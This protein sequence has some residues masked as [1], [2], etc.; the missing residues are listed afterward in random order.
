SRDEVR[1][2]EMVVAAARPVGLP[3]FRWTATEGLTRQDVDSGPPQ[4]F[5]AEA[6]EVLRTIRQ[7]DLAG[8]Y[9][10]VD[11][12]P[13]L[14]DP[15]HVRLL[16]DIAQGYPVVARTVVL[17][18]YALD[19]PP[20]LEHLAARLQVALPGGPERLAI[21]ETAVREWS[22]EHGQ[23]VPV[24]PRARD[25]LVE[26]LRGL[27]AV[28]AERLARGAVADGA[29]RPS[30]LP[31]VMQ[32]KYALL[33]RD[34]VLGYEHDVPSV[35]D[36]GGMGRLVRWLE[37]RRAAFD[38]S[39]PD[40]DTPRGVLLVGVQGCGKS[41][42]AKA[43][44][45]VLGVPLLH[46]DLAAVHNKYV[47]E[48]ERILRETL[49]T[50][51]VLAPCVLWIDEIE[52]ALAVDEAGATRRV[53]GTFLTWL[54]ERRSAVFVVATA[55]DVTDLPPE[56]VRKGRFDEIF[57]VDLPD[58]DARRHI[59]QVHA[60]RRGLVLGPAQAAGLAAASAGFSGAEL[61]Q[62]VVS[63]RYAAHDGGGPV[64]AEHVLAEIRA[65][66]PLSV[67][68][69]ERIGALR[70]WADGRTVPAAG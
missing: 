50:A 11:L 4:R 17:L 10:L 69:A 6:G 57:F 34:G 49:R 46:L 39:S 52:K 22:R 58:D 1:A 19:L 23:L 70:R 21:V 2:L 42:L 64:T 55:N 41:M 44:A 7:T 31:A 5:N 14:D 26:N 27:S 36:V 51:E 13:F 53:L 12:H 45:G 47:G 66:S 28:E 9:V 24:D 68:L 40:L 16:K 33:N 38:G 56:L 65:T 15:V 60:A 48:S 62:A 37:L 3:V 61:E 20:E 30:D 18:S 67:V 29:L 32:A 63:A 25:L 54:A 43:A 8:V 59:L 35:R